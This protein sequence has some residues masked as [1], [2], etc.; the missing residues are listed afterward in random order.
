MPLRKPRLRFL[1]LVGMALLIGGYAGSRFELTGLIIRQPK[2]LAWKVIE[3]ADVESGAL[4][5]ADTNVVFH[6]PQ[7]F[8]KLHREVLLGHKGKQVR[9]WGYCFP[10][11]YDPETVE[12]RSG[13]PGQVFLSEKEREAQEVFT[14]RQEAR[15]TLRRLPTKR[16]L[17]LPDRKLGGIRHMFDFFTPGMLC[18][19]QT[20]SELA[21]GLD[22]DADKLNDRLE[23]EIGTDPRRPDSDADGLIDGVEFLNGTSPTL[24]DTDSDGLLDGIEDKNWDGDIDRGET[25]PRVWDSDRDRLCDG[26]CRVR[27]KGRNEAFLGEDR[28]LNG[29]L[30][31]GETSPLLVDSDKDGIRDEQEFLNCLSANRPN[32]PN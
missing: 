13:L 28:N 22:V 2:Q 21:I 23:H 16:E 4:I 3:E 26:W 19:I 1:A 9:Y 15:F 32:C 17:E 18:Y 24:R 29:E 5:P 6:L 8:N 25:D 7:T 10:A 27:L 12:R 31:S 20:E 14:K 11:N 30:D